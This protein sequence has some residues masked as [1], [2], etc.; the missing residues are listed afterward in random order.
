MSD[1]SNIAQME[2][3]RARRGLAPINPFEIEGSGTGFPPLT[4]QDLVEDGTLKPPP[5]V[6]DQAPTLPTPRPPTLLMNPLPE[7]AEPEE[8]TYQL[9]IGDAH[10]SY[11]GHEVELSEAEQGLVAAI[12]LRA[13]RRR[14]NEQYRALRA[15][16]PKPPVRRPSPSRRSPQPRRRNGTARQEAPAG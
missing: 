16:V 4:V 3:V 1:L 14:V 8:P 6:A 9:M 7:P 13:I 11:L 12:V 10:A 2:A 5:E 15:R